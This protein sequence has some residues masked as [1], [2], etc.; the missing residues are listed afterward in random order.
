MRSLAEC[1]ASVRN[2][3]IRIHEIAAKLS[4]AVAMVGGDPCPAGN[5]QNCNEGGERVERVR[6]EK[7]S[8]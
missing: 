6:R 3:Q 2:S 7:E 5:P 1:F 4:R 8:T